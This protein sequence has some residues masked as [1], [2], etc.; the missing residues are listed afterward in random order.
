MTNDSWVLVVQ[1]ALTAGLVWFGGAQ[2]WAQQKATRDRKRTAYTALYSEFTRLDAVRDSWKDE[3]LV[4][5]AEAGLLNASGLAHRDWGIVIQLLAEVSSG[6]S[7]MGG[8]AYQTVA[9]A[10]ER[11]LVLIDGVQAH[12]ISVSAARSLESQIKDGL[13][14]AVNAF[15]DAMRCAPSNLATHEFTIADPTSKVG[16]GIEQHLIRLRTN[17]TSGRHEPRFGRVGKFVGKY[18]TKAGRWFDPAA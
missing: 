5:L 4:K 8:F 14:E 17:F 9:D 6:T 12:K 15:A 11:A 16:K 1:V 18:L 13:E 7:I 3:D 10:M 2:V